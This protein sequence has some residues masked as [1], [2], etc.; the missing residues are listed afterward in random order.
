MGET[1]R[2]YCA[3]G[4]SN[5]TVE[6]PPVAL[7]PR[8]TMTLNLV[9]HELATNAAKHGALSTET[10]HVTISWQV[11]EMSRPMLVMRWVEEGGPPVQDSG[12]RGFGSQL[13][14]LMLSQT[15]G[16]QSAIELAGT[17]LQAEFTLPLSSEGATLEG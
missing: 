7:S 14:K 5:C 11:E 17:G 4:G 12:R 15:R 10:G 16:A 13:I 6:G 8:L 2:P 1:L 9:M 3:E